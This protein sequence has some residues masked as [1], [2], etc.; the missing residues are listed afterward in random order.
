MTRRCKTEEEKARGK[1]LGKAIKEKREASQMSGEDVAANAGIPIDTLRGLEQGRVAD[2]GV[3][4]VAAVA[5]AMG[6]DVADLVA[7]ANPETEV[8]GR[9]V[10]DPICDPHCGRAT[11]DRIEFAVCGKDLGCG[12]GLLRRV[13]HGGVLD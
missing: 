6:C 8:M 9:L 1:R 13:R 7:A 5:S 11:H 3:F 12:V 2:P 10:P 4:V